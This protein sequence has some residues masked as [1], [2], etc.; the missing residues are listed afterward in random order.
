M[1]ISGQIAAFWRFHAK[2]T[3]KYKVHSP[4][5]YDL[6]TEVLEDDRYFQAFGM[7]AQTRRE[8]LKDNRTLNVTDYGAGSQ[9]MGQKQRKVSE[10]AK[11]A[12]SS[13]AQGQTLF[14]LVNFCKPTTILELGTSL[15]LGTL[16]LHHARQR[17]QMISLEGCPETAKVAAEVLR[18]RSN[19]HL[20]LITGRF[21]ETLPQAIEQL[22]TLDFVFFDGHHDGEATYQYFITCLEKARPESVFVFDDIHWSKDMEQA[23]QRI[24][25]HPRVRLSVETWD[26]GIVFFREE[27]RQKEHFTLVPYLWKP[28]VIGLF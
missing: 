21:V 19:N 1:K 9:T 27:Q 28:W 11:N 24:C 6:L 5:V 15:G 4:F 26:L 2:A 17:A 16:Y 7:I 23:W 3:N 12:A 13:E 20:K 10:I 8:L 14:R 25:E 18:T 22:P